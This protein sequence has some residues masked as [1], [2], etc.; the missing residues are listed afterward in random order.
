MLDI[1]IYMNVILTC[2]LFYI[3]MKIEFIQMLLVRLSILCIIQM[4]TVMYSVFILILRLHTL[5]ETE[6]ETV[7]IK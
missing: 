7:S 3:R 5:T 6:T 2:R 1:C 4:C